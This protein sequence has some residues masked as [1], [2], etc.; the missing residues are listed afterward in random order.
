[1][2]AKKIHLCAIRL[3]SCMTLQRYSLIFGLL[4]ALSPQLLGQK[5]LAYTD[6]AYEP[7]IQTIQFYPASSTVQ[8]TLEPAVIGMNDGKEWQLHFDDLRQDA[9]Y[10]YVRFIHC[11]ADWTPSRLK[12]NMYLGQYNEFEIV[13]F[14]FSSES[15][16]QYV[17]YSFTIPKLLNTGNYLAVVY[18][19]QNKND[20]ILSKQFSVYDNSVGVGARIDRSAQT[21][22][23]LVNQ[24]IE[25]TMNYANL[26][27]VNPAEQFRVVVRQNERPDRIK[28]LSPTYIDE[29][30][31]LIRYQNLG[32]EN[33][34]KGGNEFR[35][36][37]LS[38]VNFGGRNV[39]NTR[40]V[41]NKPITD[42]RVDRPASVGY[43]INL[44]I[45]GKFYV[46]DIEG[47]NSTITS[48]YIQVN[49]TLETDELNE[50]VYVLGA[51][52]QWKKSKE[53]LMV[54]NPSK[55]VYQNQQLIKQ[56]WY[57]YT[58]QTEHTETSA[59]EGSFFETENLYEVFVYYRAMGARGDELVGYSKVNFNRRR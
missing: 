46:R 2:V 58:Y 45:N 33:E 20:I 16:T 44:D 36:F 30:D 48:E 4:I 35:H 41:D 54:Y 19:G 26:S 43:L 6:K 53:S 57:D 47:R 22:E 28:A 23:R 50:P 51:F 8:G 14:E 1:M 29:N 25:V 7:T 39:A 27:T 38:S 24:R 31:K 37:D 11:N 18:R 56:G 17:H 21:S 32:E 34:F 15:R 59:L 3:F 55:G 12:P 9:D 5:K 10:Y 40:F 42:L 13:D 49:F 52:N